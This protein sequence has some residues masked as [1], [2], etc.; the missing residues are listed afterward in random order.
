MARV[1]RL[2]Q[3][4]AWALGPVAGYYVRKLICAPQP[5]PRALPEEFQPG[6]NHVMPMVGPDGTR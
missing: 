2:G 3:V 5:A 6:F 1:D 4:G